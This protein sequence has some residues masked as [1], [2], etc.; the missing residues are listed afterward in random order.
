MSSLHSNSCLVLNSRCQCRFKFP[1]LW[2]SQAHDLCVT[3]G[4]NVLEFTFNYIRLFLFVVTCPSN[5]TRGTMSL[6][7]LE[8]YILIQNIN[9]FRCLFAMAHFFTTSVDLLASLEGPQ[10]SPSLLLLA[11]GRGWTMRLQDMA[12]AEGYAALPLV[13]YSWSMLGSAFFW[14]LPPKKF[15]WQTLEMFD[16]SR[17]LTDDKLKNIVFILFLS[18]LLLFPSLR[19]SFVYIYYTFFSI[20]INLADIWLLCIFQKKPLKDW[21][22]KL[23]PASK[24]K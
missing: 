16:T 5:P 13:L 20:L 11:H 9:I 3:L 7:P 10:H 17:D 18:I 15:Q 19:Y 4:V 21:T 1:S 12:G 22:N 2:R 23:N 8:D 24:V 14:V 6:L